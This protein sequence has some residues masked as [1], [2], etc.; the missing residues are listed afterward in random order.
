MTVS[1]RSPGVSSQRASKLSR[2]KGG[3]S[4]QLIQVHDDT[5]ELP[6]EKLEDIFCSPPRPA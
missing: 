3:C 4:R 5:K 6:G 2:G 1:R